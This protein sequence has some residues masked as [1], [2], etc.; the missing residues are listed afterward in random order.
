MNPP[1]P[2]LGKQWDGSHR[3]SELPNL[4]IFREGGC[5]NLDRLAANNLTLDRKL[6][7][8]ISEIHSNSV[9]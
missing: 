5:R 7:S 2:K 9:I 6:K 4:K 8:M 1:E 3:G